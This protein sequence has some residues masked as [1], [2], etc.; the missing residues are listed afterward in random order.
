MRKAI[1]FVPEVEVHNE[2][3]IVKTWNELLSFILEVYKR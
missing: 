3:K 2:W 1:V